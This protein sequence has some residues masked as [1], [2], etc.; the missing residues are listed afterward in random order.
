MKL[1]EAAGIGWGTEGA[2]PVQKEAAHGG[3][4]IDQADI[5]GQKG[6]GG[7]G[8]PQVREGGVLPVQSGRHAG[9]DLD[10]ELVV[11]LPRHPRAQQSPPPLAVPGHSSGRAATKGTPTGKDVQGL[12]K[13]RLAGAVGPKDK[14]QTRIPLKPGSSQAAKVL[15]DAKIK[16]HACSAAHVHDFPDHSFA[17]FSL[18]GSSFSGSSFS[19]DGTVGS[20]SSSMTS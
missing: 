2:E 8:K 17:G 19:I 5:S 16:P 13:V 3:G 14:V 4:T 15:D 11:F 20:S 12:Q 10:L 6:D 7:H 9:R 18:P 1:G